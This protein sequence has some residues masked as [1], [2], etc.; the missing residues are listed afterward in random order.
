MIYDERIE[1][2]TLETAAIE[3]AKINRADKPI[4][5][6]L[7]SVLSANPAGLRR[8]SVMRAI[9]KIRDSAMRDI[10]QKFEDEVERTFRRY[11]ADADN[12]KTRICSAEEALFFRPKEK[13]GEVWA[14]IPDRAKSF[15]DAA[16]G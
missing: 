13:A 9:R 15:M 5:I 4:L 7:V 12:S 11:C 10:S 3:V 1:T 6:E 16:Q 2:A 14:V 8:W